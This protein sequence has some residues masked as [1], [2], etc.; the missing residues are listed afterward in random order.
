MTKEFIGQQLI[1]MIGCMD[2]TEEGGRYDCKK[3]HAI[4]LGNCEEYI[5]FTR[6]IL[7]CYRKEQVDSEG[8]YLM[9]SL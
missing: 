1:L 8:Y 6:Y 3:T 9:I 4:V 5:F 7:K 2:I